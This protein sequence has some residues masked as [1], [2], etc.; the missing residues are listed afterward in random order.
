M[1]TDWERPGHR[2][3]GDRVS[4]TG[5]T[6]RF[7]DVACWLSIGMAVGAIGYAVVT[8]DETPAEQATA[9][10]THDEPPPSLDGPE[11]P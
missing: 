2:P 9:I 1:I 11:Q 6:N 4:F 3:E 7:M 10:V 5:L 8:S